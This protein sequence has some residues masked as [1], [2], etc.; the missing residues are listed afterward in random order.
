MSSSKKTIIKLQVPIKENL[1]E[2]GERLAAR[3]GLSSYQELIRYWT[4]QAAKGRL[5]IDTSSGLVSEPIAK[6]KA[7][8]DEA[9]ADLKSGKLKG[10]DNIDDLLEDLDKNV[11]TSKK[12][13]HL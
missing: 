7:L 12:K 13:N 9:D 4:V 8:A 5:H 6:Y 1:K 3:E 2:I 11:K 10:F